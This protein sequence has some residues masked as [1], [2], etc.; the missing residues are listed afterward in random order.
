MQK[1]CGTWNFGMHAMP[2]DRFSYSKTKSSFILQ[3]KKKNYLLLAWQVQ[4]YLFWALHSWTVGFECRLS[5]NQAQNS[6]VLC[7]SYSFVWYHLMYHREIISV[8]MT[9]ST[10]WVHKGL[11]SRL[12]VYS[13]ESN[14]HNF[15][16]KASTVFFGI[17]RHGKEKDGS[18]LFE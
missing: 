8:K 6:Y 14:F 2:F 7:L 12:A 4:L 1:N 18:Q 11:E 15:L 13:A 5:L 3:K 10:E 16:A 17:R 9:V